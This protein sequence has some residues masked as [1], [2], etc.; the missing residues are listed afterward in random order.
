MDAE[1]VQRSISSSSVVLTNT[2]GPLLAFDKKGLQTL[3]DI[4]RRIALQGGSSL[5]PPWFRYDVIT[6]PDLSI[7]AKR[8]FNVRIL[9]GTLADLLAS[10]MAPPE[11][12]KALNALDLPNP[13]AAVEQAPYATDVRAVWRTKGFEGC[14][15][16]I[17]NGDVRFGLGATEGAVSFWHF[18]PQGQGTY[19]RIAA[20][21]KLWAVAV[22]KDPGQRSSTR[23]WTDKKLDIRNLDLTQYR[24]E[25]M[26]LR[27][28]DTMCVPLSFMQATS[29]RE[30]TTS[31]QEAGVIHA[32]LTIS[33]SICHGGHYLAVSNLQQL[34][35][36]AVHAFFKGRVSTNSETDS[37]W[38]R[39]NSMA[40]F[41]YQFLVLE[42]PDEDGNPPFRIG[43]KSLLTTVQ[44]PPIYLT[45]P[46]GKAWKAWSHSHA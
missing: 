21:M 1:R 16:F 19:V 39:M 34:T 44:I 36:S 15:S 30:L 3:D 17:P 35:V 46:L 33:N 24:V 38:A 13:S 43:R 14:I 10:S 27:A 32:V 29:D 11:H 22:P 25:M 41:F 8:D 31:L 5:S 4:D 20:G 45:S 18:D 6:L 26:L 40:T 37:F 2:P 7:P 28:G 23:L 9:G 42:A 12:K